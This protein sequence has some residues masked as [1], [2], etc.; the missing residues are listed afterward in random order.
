MGPASRTTH[1]GNMQARQ[2]Y[3]VSQSSCGLQFKLTPLLSLSPPLSLCHK[4]LLS[5]R[6]PISHPLLFPPS[7][8]PHSSPLLLS[9]L[10]PPPLLSPLLISSL[11]PLPLLF[12]T[13]FS[14]SSSSFSS[15]SLSPPLLYPPLLSLLLLYSLP[16]SS[17]SVTRSS[18]SSPLSQCPH[19]PLSPLPISCSPPPFSLYLLLPPFRPP[20]CPLPL[21]LS[22]LYLSLSKTKAA[23]YTIKRFR[24]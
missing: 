11:S 15:H 13:L 5:P 10:F 6:H 9:S 2:H 23:T 14:L 8:S 12:R 16:S 7:L 17:P 20:L 19:L 18:L 24:K 4:L 3:N 22:P 1:I 21:S